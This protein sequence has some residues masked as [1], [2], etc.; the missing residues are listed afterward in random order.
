MQ[1]IGNIYGRTS[2]HAFSFK[3]SN[4]VSKWDYIIVKHAEV[5]PVLGQ[6][7]EIRRSAA[8]EIAECMIVGFRTERG[9]LRKPKT[10]LSPGSEVFHADD[11]FIKDTLG[12]VKS[13][14]YLGLLEGKDNLRTFLDPQK[15]ITKHLAVLA[16]S[17]SGKSYAIGVILEELLNFG[18]PV[19]IVDPHGEYST[20]KYPNSHPE[21]SKY[22]K[23]YGIQAKGYASQM[24]E[25]AV[26]IQLNTEA[27][28]LK[29]QIPDTPFKLGEVIPFKLSNAQKGLLYNVVNGLI[30]KKAR[31]DFQDVVQ[32]LEMN[33]S[34]AKWRLINGMQNL[35][36]T[37]LF[38][39]SPTAP[40]ELV[41]S[42]QLSIVN[43][44]G[45]PTELQEIAVSALVS[46][47]FEQ[48]KLENVPP[49]FLII[50]EAHNFCPERG[51]GEARSSKILRAVAS[52][53]RKFGLGLCI[54]SQRPGRVDKNVLSQCTSQI[55]LQVTNPNDLKAI[56]HSFEGVTAETEREIKNLPVGKALV[57]GS[58]DYP[59]FVD[60]RVRKSQHGGRAKAFEM[61]QK[62]PSAVESRDMIYMFM[63]RVSQKDVEVLEAR[64][65]KSAVMV[66]QPCLV[67]NCSVG[68]KNVQLVFDLQEMKI[69]TLSNKLNAL[70]IPAHLVRLSPMQRKVLGAA[71][72]GAAISEV[73]MKSGLGFSEVESVVRGLVEKGLLQVNGKRVSAAGITNAS[74]LATLHFL[75]K[76]RYVEAPRVE[77]RAIK[78]AES[79]VL[80]FLSMFGVNVIG[81]KVCYLPFWKV[82]S[83]EDKIVDGF[84]YSLILA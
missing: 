21:D 16:K 3:V 11:G 58:A 8:E 56:A 35:E 38:S 65:L 67:V 76:P 80:D 69:Y 45:A 72:T 34:V 9:F 39:F 51:F 82:K 70:K 47:L 2:T 12:L 54:I 73:F 50:E 48:R 66:L 79:Q 19:V 55:S 42:G 64:S 68:S 49:F 10:P 71:G 61:E 32:E 1:S 5:G 81:K 63:P 37:N 15:L 84:G 60:V 59:I 36:K 27:Q 46:D 41:K 22:F 33:E 78:L 74:K 29:L 53:G 62:E 20:I 23:N 28:Q 44:R 6:V 24:R 13:G 7:I 31:F 4:K 17:G 75:D 52:E 83:K 25:Y 30:D 57:I 18:V 77:T 26:N 14:L 40:S 43:L